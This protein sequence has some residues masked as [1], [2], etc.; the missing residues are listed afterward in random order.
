MFGLST[1]PAPPE[2]PAAGWFGKLPATGDF[3]SR[4]LP[5]EFVNAWDTFLG[6]AVAGS[7]AL[8]G[9][10][11][12]EHYL[13]SPIWQFVAFPPLCGAGAWAGLM[14]PSVDRVGRYFPLTI[15]S[16]LRSIPDSREG[17][18]SLLDWLGTLEG[19]ALGALDPDASV[20]DL[21]QALQR[22]AELSPLPSERVAGAPPENN[23]L[24]VPGLFM[25]REGPEMSNWLAQIFQDPVAM[26]GH[27]IWW[28]FAVA[29]D[30]VPAAIVRGLPTPQSYARMIGGDF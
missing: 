15:C 6:N 21:E 7:K 13:A 27:S 24:L 5:P 30:R 8:L 26:A 29:G 17:A 14:M 1:P 10:T 18:D 25:L 16:R 23:D 11:W 28:S 2:A 20:E 3:V 4:R 22:Q 12:L 19:A 9:S